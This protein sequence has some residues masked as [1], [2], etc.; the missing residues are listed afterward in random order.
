MSPERDEASFR[1]RMLL[2]HRLYPLISS[3]AALKALLEELRGALYYP[4][5]VRPSRRMTGEIARH[6][7]LLQELRGLEVELDRLYSEDG[8][9]SDLSNP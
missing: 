9:D 7:D 5:D 3:A 4:P 2:V 8:A 1:E 6:L